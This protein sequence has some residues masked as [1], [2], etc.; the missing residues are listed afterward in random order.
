MTE[1]EGRTELS[2]AKR[3]QILR[4]ARAVFESLG[5]ERA[6]VDAIAARAGVSKAT[7]YNHFRS[8]EALFL[9]TLGAETRGLREK[10]LSV[11]ETPSGD[12]ASDLQTI[13][14]HLVRLVTDAATVRRFR[15]VAAQ[16]ER[17]PELGRAYHACTLQVGQERLA[18]FLE[19][20]AERGLIEVD[21]AAEA[22]QDFRGLC[23]GDLPQRRLLGVDVGNEEALRERV[24]RAVRVFLRAHRPSARRRWEAAY[25]A[26]TYVAQDGETTLEIRV[27]AK[28]PAL[29]ERL[30]A[31]GAREWAYITAYNPRSIP[32]SPAANEAAQA[33]LEMELEARGVAFLRGA[34]RPDDGS[35]P[36]ASVLAF[37]PHEE[38][39]LLG[40]A[41]GQ[42]AIVVGALGGPAEL[43]WLED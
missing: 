32:L 33:R 30:R 2:P 36:E 16:A 19:R 6:S 13:G 20:A 28:T 24:R 4:G 29:D 12:L 34:S 37:L 3:E 8:K 1:H 5:Y 7:V 14:E 21:D 42:N 22:A 23:V 40:R 18:R 10:F 17:F 9:A 11:L 31:R 26:T 38:A 35:A 43:L 41:F 27:G 15:V 39:I 25:R